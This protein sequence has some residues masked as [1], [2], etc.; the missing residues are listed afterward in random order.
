MDRYAP[1]FGWRVVLG[2]QLLAG[3]ILTTGLVFLPETPRWLA[4]KG[5][6]EK[7]LAVLRKVHKLEEKAR[8]EL[9][10]IEE[11]IVDTSTRDLLRLVCNFKMFKRYGIIM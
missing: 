2:L 7:A 5:R 6:S 11:S 9:K 4:K 8:A 10:E 3:A 1:G